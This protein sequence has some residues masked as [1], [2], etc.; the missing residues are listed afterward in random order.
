M[1]L[2]GKE[3]EDTSEGVDAEAYEDRGDDNEEKGLEVPAL[4]VCVDRDRRNMA[5]DMRI[6]HGTGH[7]D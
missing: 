5:L 2:E 1:R 3:A 7:E 4:H 6:K